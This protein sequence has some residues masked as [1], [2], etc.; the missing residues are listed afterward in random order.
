[1]CTT[2]QHN[3]LKLNI[4]NGTR[5]RA[6]PFTG[7]NFR[8][9]QPR[10]RGP[11]WR[12]GSRETKASR[13]GWNREKRL[14]T[15]EGKVCR[16][17]RVTS[18]PSASCTGWCRSPSCRPSSWV[19]TSAP[20]A[21]TTWTRSHRWR[22]TISKLSSARIQMQRSVQFSCLNAERSVQQGSRC[23]GQFSCLNAERSVQQGSSCK[24]Q[25]SSVV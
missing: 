16:D 22:A 15:E 8:S 25:F 9:R 18:P 11:R 12:A 4:F 14:G 21:W 7:N 6:A 10:V 13:S 2:D 20:S 5:T 1:M 17:V 19:C 24:S 3:T 23:K